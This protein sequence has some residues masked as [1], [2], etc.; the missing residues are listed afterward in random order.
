MARAV[1]TEKMYS[2]REG[3]AQIVNRGAGEKLLRLGQSPLLKTGSGFRDLDPAHS[4]TPKKVGVLRFQLVYFVFG[5]SRCAGIQVD[6]HT[7]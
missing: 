3:T 5:T 6:G 7:L 1:D 4:K 2:G